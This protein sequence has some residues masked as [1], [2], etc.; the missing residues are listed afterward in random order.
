[1]TVTNPPA[2][3]HGRPRLPR[4]EARSER[5]VTFVTPPEMEELTARAQR[6][7]KS[8]STTCHEL[9]QRAMAVTTNDAGDRT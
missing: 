7:G 1:M 9:I 3:R 2:S 6:T 5:V 4:S 8:L